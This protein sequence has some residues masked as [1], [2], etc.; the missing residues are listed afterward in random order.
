MQ[1]HEDSGL[2]ARRDVARSPAMPDQQPR[3]Q[4]SSQST[5]RYVKEN[6]NNAL[7]RLSQMHYLILQ[8]KHV[9]H[10]YH[11]VDFSVRS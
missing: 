11:S 6:E 4:L 8:C 10:C 5:S 2:F 3:A 9:L 7:Y 1:E